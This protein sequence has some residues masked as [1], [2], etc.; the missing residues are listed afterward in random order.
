[1][2]RAPHAS[3]RLVLE[4]GFV[5]G[6][7]AD[8]LRSWECPFVGSIPPGDGAAAVEHVW[9]L[10]W[11]HTFHLFECVGYPV[12][13]CQVAGPF[14]DE[15][16]AEASTALRFLDVDDLLAACARAANGDEAAAAVFALGLAAGDTPEDGVVD[17][18]RAASARP[19]PRARIAALDAAFVT[20]WDVFAQD[21]ERAAASDPDPLVRET[22]ANAVAARG[23]R[24]AGSP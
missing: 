8:A 9:K 16:L 1:M 24:G 2:A 12:E 21:F 13:Y 19:E 17:R 20:G 6:G 23:D 18:I 11:A 4:S 15:T 10:D 14:A 5:G 22:A 3:R 7:L